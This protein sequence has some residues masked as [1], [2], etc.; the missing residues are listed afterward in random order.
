[1]AEKEESRTLLKKP[2]RRWLPTILLGV[3]I[4]VCGL[5]LGSGITVGAVWRVIH[6]SFRDPVR[7]TERIV[8]HMQRNLDLNEEQARKVKMILEK[9]MPAFVKLR[10]QVREELEQVRRELAEVLTPEQAEKFNRDFRRLDRRWL[11]P[12]APSP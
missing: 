10:R 4:L 3:A 7:L 9:R 12:P 6:K 8:R 1:M 2:R 11:P 5:V